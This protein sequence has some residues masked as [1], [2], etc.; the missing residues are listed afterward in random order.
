MGQFYHC[1]RA[2]PN[3]TPPKI[4]ILLH[5]QPLIKILDLKWRDSELIHPDNIEINEIKTKM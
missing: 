2:H 1:D 4:I 3:S 5:S